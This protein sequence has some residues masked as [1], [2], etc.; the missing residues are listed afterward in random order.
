M[1]ERTLV[2]KVKG[3]EPESFIFVTVK[4]N[5]SGITRMSYPALSADDLWAALHKQ[6]MPEEEIKVM[7]EQA[8]KNPV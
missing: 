6:G 3:S 7:I 2:A 5:F 1:A 8:R 4:D